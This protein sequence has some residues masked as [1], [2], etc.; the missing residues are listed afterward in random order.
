M[1]WKLTLAQYDAILVVIENLLKGIRDSPLT[2][3][4][5]LYK[6][7]IDDVYFKAEVGYFK[8]KKTQKKEGTF[9]LTVTQSATFWILMSQVLDSEVMQGNTSLECAVATMLCRDIHQKLLT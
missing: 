7:I 8:L 2:P 3:F 9:S 5:V 1:K 4:K 6:D